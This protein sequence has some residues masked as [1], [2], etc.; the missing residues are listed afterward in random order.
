MSEAALLLELAAHL[1]HAGSSREQRTEYDKGWVAA[2]RTIAGLLRQRAAGDRSVQDR[3]GQ[4][5]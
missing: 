4:G 1:D 5:G 3:R 2:H